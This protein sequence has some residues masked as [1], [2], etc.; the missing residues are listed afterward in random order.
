LTFLS[1]AAESERLKEL[2]VIKEYRDSLKKAL[3]NNKKLNT[4][5]K[6]LDAGALDNPKNLTSFYIELTNY[7]NVIRSSTKDFRKRLENLK[8]HS[9]VKM[10]DL[11]K[12]D[13][14]FR[15]AGDT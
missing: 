12:D 9:K 2:T 15:A 13:Y 4:F 3:P 5:L 14:R 8:K 7:L 11:A 1:N 10:K 6:Q